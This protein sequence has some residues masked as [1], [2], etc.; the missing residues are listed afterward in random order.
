LSATRQFRN[1]GWEL[2]AA[3]QFLT[4]IP[5]P[6]IPFEENSLSQSVKFFPLVGLAIGSGAALLQ[7]I[8]TVHMARPLT[9]FVVLIYLVIITGC[10]KTD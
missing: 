1:F 8:L 9:A 2:A 5:M 3:F 6:S 10:T 4:R 7:R